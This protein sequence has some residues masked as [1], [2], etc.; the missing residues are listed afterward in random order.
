MRDVITINPYSAW[1]LF[2]IKKYKT[3]A[4]LLV[5]YETS[6]R[7]GNTNTVPQDKGF[8][9]Y[10]YKQQYL[11]DQNMREIIKNKYHNRLGLYSP[12]TDY[13]THI[14]YYHC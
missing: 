12:V 1:L 6:T 7:E 3:K 14:P 4:M 8:I 11:Q 10:Y 2:T 9:P 5:K 13:S